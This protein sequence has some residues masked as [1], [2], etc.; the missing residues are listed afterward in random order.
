[1]GELAAHEA[2]GAIKGSFLT[3]ARF[4]EDRER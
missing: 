3:I 2:D 4:D 1:M